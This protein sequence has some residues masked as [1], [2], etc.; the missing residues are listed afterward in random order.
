MAERV[1]NARGLRER[2]CVYCTSCLS[3]FAISLFLL[4][5][6]E[7]GH[8]AVLRFTFWTNDVSDIRMTVF[9]ISC[10]CRM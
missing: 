6:V 5:T 10:T 7:T 2:K 4:K 8:K 1:K 9:S 3:L